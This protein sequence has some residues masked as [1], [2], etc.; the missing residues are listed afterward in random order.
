MAVVKNQYIIPLWFS[1]IFSLFPN[2]KLSS[3]FGQLLLTEVRLMLKGLHW[4]WYIVAIALIVTS[5]ALPIDA[6]KNY[7]LP[8]SWIWP[9]LLWSK[10]GVRE[11]YY[12]TNQLLFS[13]PYFRS[14]QLVAIWIAGVLLALLIGIG[15][16]I[17]LILAGEG[18]SF[19]G[20][21]AGVSFIPSFSLVLGVWS[22]SSKLFE[23]IYSI[24]W[25]IGPLN[26]VSQLD[27]TG[28]SSSAGIASI[29][30]VL[31]IVCLCLA[32]LGRQ[33]QVEV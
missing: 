33:R 5:L 3:C 32:Y 7:I 13:A 1:K 2:V 27:F 28:A 25:Y 4:M 30:I 12:H 14:R 20:F 8:C 18:Q 15:A 29:Y 22:G 17:H 24:W 9:I 31:S 26:Q 11:S 21:F 19:Y 6:V 23:A 10:M 16:G